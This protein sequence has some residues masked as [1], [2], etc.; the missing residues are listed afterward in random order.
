MEQRRITEF[1]D[2]PVD[3]LDSLFELLNFSFSPADVVRVQAASRLGKTYYGY[4]YY[5]SL[6]QE[7][8]HGFLESEAYDYDGDEIAKEVDVSLG[9]SIV[10]HGSAHIQRVYSIG[11]TLSTILA[12]TQP[13]LSGNVIHASLKE[14]GTDSTK[15]LD[16]NER[17]LLTLNRIRQIATHLHDIGNFG[18]RNNHTAIGAAATRIILEDRGFPIDICNLASAAV[19]LHTASPLCLIDLS[20]NSLKKNILTLEENSILG[21]C[22]KDVTDILFF[23]ST[24][25]FLA[26]KLDIRGGRVLPQQKDSLIGAALSRESLNIHHVQNLIGEGPQ[27]NLDSRNHVLE[28]T[29]S[30][31]PLALIAQLATD[32][33]ADLVTDERNLYI[34]QA[35]LSA[36][37]GGE[38]AVKQ[39]PDL[40]ARLT[41]EAIKMGNY[42]AIN[43]IALMLYP[44]ILLMSREK[45]GIQEQRLMKFLAAFPGDTARQL[46]ENLRAA[47]GPQLALGAECLR[48][49]TND[50]LMNLVLQTDLFGDDRFIFDSQ[51]LQ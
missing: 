46:V 18:G 10:E 13:L 11:D 44:Q 16:Q 2:S 15:G 12:R 43:R 25:L 36:L 35:C 51:R 42:D 41:E 20:T 39:I 7:H 37:K 32:K 26:D 14:S 22:D 27:L 28:A 3:Q 38:A 49:L 4:S 6:A 29:Y 23:I 45:G 34:Y 48:Y 19:A 5:Y 31:S 33:S 50:P 24:I 9:G 1:V 8:E 47:Y 21:D 30:A 40:F 17:Y